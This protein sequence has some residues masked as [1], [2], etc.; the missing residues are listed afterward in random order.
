MYLIF[1]LL[2]YGIVLARDV[3]NEYTHNRKGFFQLL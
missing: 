1:I 3:I 2:I